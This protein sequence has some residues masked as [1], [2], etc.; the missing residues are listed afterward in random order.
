MMPAVTGMSAPALLIGLT[1]EIAPTRR[2]WTKARYPT[3]NEA[4]ASVIHMSEA[5]SG[6][7]GRTTSQATTSTGTPTAWRASRVRA[8]PIRRVTWAAR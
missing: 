6:R 8:S 1:I 4:E 2:P 3:A 7:G 5:G